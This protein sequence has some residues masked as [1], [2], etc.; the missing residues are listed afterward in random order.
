M[1]GVLGLGRQTAVSAREGISRAAN[2][3]S[4]RDSRNEQLEAADDAAQASNTG[5]GA[6]I[7]YMANAGGAAAT[8]GGG[9]VAGAEAG[10]IGGPMGMAI[11]A[12]AGYILSEWL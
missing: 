2:L 8:A 5:T 7:G 12:V 11:G 4:S 6:A 1:A 3:K 9:A 10:T